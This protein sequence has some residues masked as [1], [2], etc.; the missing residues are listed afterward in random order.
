MMLPILFELAWCRMRIRALL[1]TL[2]RRHPGFYE[3][4]TTA[5]IE[6]ASRDFY[7]IAEQMTLADD[8]PEYLTRHRHWAEDDDARLR[9]LLG[10]EVSAR[11]AAAWTAF[12]NAER[13][14][15]R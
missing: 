15:S 5:L 3:E 11:M 12:D 9:D 7:A 6:G 4:Y 10:P 14:A 2:E 8:A 13:S 1:E